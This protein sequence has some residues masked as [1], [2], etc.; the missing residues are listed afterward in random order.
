MTRIMSHCIQCGT[1][2][3]LL[4]HMFT[5]QML[6]TSDDVDDVNAANLTSHFTVVIV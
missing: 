4:Q 1:I 6:A 2:T 5:I 3:L